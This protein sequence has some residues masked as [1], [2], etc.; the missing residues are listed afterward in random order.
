MK[1]TISIILFTVIQVFA[2]ANAQKITLSETNTPVSIV[3]AKIQKQS[4]Y[5]FFYK[6]DLL[7]D[8][9][10][11]VKLTNASLE[12]A[13]HA[14][15]DKQ[16]LEFSLEDKLITIQKSRIEP[17]AQNKP[18][19]PVRIKGI[20]VGEDGKGLPAAT[21]YLIGKKISRT[22]TQPDGSFEF[23]T[24]EG[25]S[26]LNV[27]YVGYAMKSVRIVP[28]KTNYRIVMQA[29]DADLKAVV[30][31]GMF[32]KPKESFTGAVTVITKEQ[33]KMF[34][35]RN[36]LKTIG[37]ID[38]AFNIE[39]QSIS[40]SNPNAL[41]NISIRGTSTIPTDLTNIQS[42]NIRNAYNVPLFILDGFEVTLQRVMDMNQNDVESVVILKDASSTAAYGARGAN[43]VVVI[44]SIKPVGGKIRISYSAG[45]NIEIPDFSSYNLLGSADKLAIERKAGLYTS[46]SI[47]TQDSYNQLYNANL[48]ATVEGVDTKWAQIPTQVG[49]GQVH[50]IGLSGGD[51]E[52]RYTL[53]GSYNQITGVMKGS[54]RDNFNGGITLSYIL[55]KVR[56]TNNLSVGFNNSSNST[57]GDFSSY[58]TMN[59]YWN[60]Y[61]ANGR[62]VAQFTGFGGTYTNPAYNGSLPDF[63]KTK[64]TVFRNTTSLDWDII[65]GL[66]SSSS[67]GYNRQVGSSDIFRSPSNSAFLQNSATTKGSYNLINDFQQS[68]Q[69]RTTLS[70]GTVIGKSTVF[71]G[72][73]GQVTEDKANGNALTATGFSNDQQSNLADAINSGR[74]TTTESTTRTVGASF[75][76]SYNFD[77]RFFVDANYNL[78]GGSSFGANSKFGTFYSA[79]LGWTISNER[80]M[81][82]LLPK[83]N[84]LRIRYNY[85][86]SG[87][88]NFD[89]YQSLSSYQYDRTALYRSLSGANLI[90]FGNKDLQW[91]NTYQHNAGIDMGLFD[92]LLT[93]SANY[94]FK[95]TNNAITTANLSYSHGFSSYI[96]NFGKVNNY[97]SDITASVFLVRN[98]AKKFYWSVT[99]SAAHNKNILV[100]L[101][102]AL[103]KAN[104]LA[105]SSNS[106]GQVYYQYVEGQSTDAVY[107]LQSPGVDAATGKVLYL[108]ADGTLTTAISGDLPK[109]VVGQSI[110]K[111]DGRLSTMIRIGQFAANIGFAARFG[112]TKVNYTLLNKVEN[113][114][115]R[116]NVDARVSDYRWS[117]PGDVTG[118]KSLTVTD[119]TYPNNR[120]AFTETTFLLNNININYSL[121]AKLVK[122]LDVQQITVSATMS[123]IGYWSNIEQERGTSYPYSLKPSF[124]LSCTF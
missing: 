6:N 24:S 115:L 31:T 103:K 82:E 93:L 94:Y 25:D 20:V 76:A 4:G 38:P 112:A 60:P 113:A 1:L 51:N 72:F 8:S 88:M 35:N 55:K 108:K 9:K 80:F 26:V 52:F 14:V 21:V 104:Q 77:G 117:A 68:Y 111:V 44:T 98:P 85:G 90:S 92:G 48:K 32:D 120:F 109:V 61:D 57:W 5:D 54:K 53:N 97:G 7:T 28:G 42:T 43:G 118:F 114:F 102:D 22:A 74:P 16:H 106:S 101:S 83:V 58:I 39:E 45:L 73:N 33:I 17:K 67:I 46:T 69:A 78:T 47:S 11:S 124:S 89:P 75:T 40:G 70:Y 41:P 10:V 36:L 18:L 34:G 2:T 29:Q 99:A 37:N 62:A 122:H 87:G 123:D 12:A 105:A 110:P 107:V 96:E 91:Q 119:N 27:S 63:D 13:L 65:K 59:P 84:S 19:P 3:L 81:K 71:A 15:L 30:V 66:K 56:F 49:I 121:P 79:G 64:Y 116:V 95:T 86:V 100:K 50:S 23:M